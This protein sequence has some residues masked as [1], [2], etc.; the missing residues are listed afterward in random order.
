ME[1]LF[2]KINEEDY[3]KPILVKCS[4]K[5]KYKYHESRGDR[6]KIISKTIS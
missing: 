5:G 3:Y 4:F 2:D 1:S 6:K